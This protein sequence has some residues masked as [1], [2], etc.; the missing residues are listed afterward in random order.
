MAQAITRGTETIL[1]FEDEAELRELAKEVL[2]AA[3]YT[4][5]EA[6]AAADAMLIAR[7]HA[8]VSEL[9]SPMSPCRA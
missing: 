1:L 4:V 3:G 2:E 6:A 5:L 8:G 9:C 7:R